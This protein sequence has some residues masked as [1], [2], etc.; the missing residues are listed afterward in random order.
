[1]GM[2]RSAHPAIGAD[3][4]AYAAPRSRGR[5]IGALLAAAALA[6]AA[7]GGLALH[8]FA[9]ARE[10]PAVAPPPSLLRSV[11]DRRPVTITLT[12]PE[13]TK[14]R[15]VVTVAELRSDRR[16]WRQMHVGDWDKIPEAIREPA[17][18]NMIGAYAP[19][20]DDPGKW[21]QMSAADWDDV[22]QPVRAMAYLRMIWHWAA[23]E[24][25]GMEFGLQPSRVAHSI[26]AIV[27]A[28]SWFEHRA[29]NQ[30][31]WGRDLGLAQCSTFCQR[32]MAV[33]ALTGMI[34]F[35]PSENDYFNPWLATRVA[36]VWF[37]REL[38]RADGDVELAIRAYHRGIDAAMDKKGDVYLAG[39]L[40]L[41]E[42]YVRG[43][44]ASASW[45]FL[46]RTIAPL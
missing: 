33:M 40:R 34:R 35:A 39:V 10:N 4:L 21:R 43:Q 19:V 25:V 29:V 45:R 22:P 5:R 24:R 36:T 1:M 13:W 2:A 38:I 14:V 23:A 32:I 44:T 30:N 7:A 41:R 9:T 12:T 8:E 15:E 37:K 17:L 31:E 18:R 11:V 28:E 46:A 26:G 20:F 3:G 42:Q 6:A 27:M 16:L